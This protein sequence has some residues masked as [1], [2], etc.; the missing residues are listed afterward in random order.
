MTTNAAPGGPRR[1]RRMPAK[2]HKVTFQVDPATPSAE[3]GESVSALT[4]TWEIQ[5]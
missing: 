3:H 1:S 2:S 5:S 4:F